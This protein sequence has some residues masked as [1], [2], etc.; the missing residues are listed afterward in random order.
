MWEKKFNLC[1][2]KIIQINEFIFIRKIIK[3]CFQMMSIHLKNIS[4]I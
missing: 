2:K 4:I 3:V 1:K